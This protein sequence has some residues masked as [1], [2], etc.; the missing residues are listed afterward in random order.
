MKTLD[1]AKMVMVWVHP[2]TNGES[3]RRVIADAI[4]LYPMDVKT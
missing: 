4:S 1:A 2:M 3:M